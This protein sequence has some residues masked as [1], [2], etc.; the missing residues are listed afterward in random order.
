MDKKY[1]DFRHIMAVIDPTTARGSTLRRAFRVAQA[2][3]GSRVTAYLCV[4]SG[5]SASD[6]E[7][8]IETEKERHKLWVEH[9]IGWMDTGGIPCEIV[10]DY[11][12][13]WGT[14]IVEATRRLSPDLLVKAC[15]RPGGGGLLGRE[16]TNQKRL[17]YADQQLIRETTCPVLFAKGP[18]HEGKRVALAAIAAEKENEV[19][20][21]L[22]DRI[23][24]VGKEFV[25]HAPG[26][27]LHVV[28]AAESWDSFKHPT[29]LLERSGLPQDKV[30][31]RGGKVPEVVAEVAE[32]IGANLIIIGTTGRDGVAAWALGNVA[33]RILD[34][35]DI[36][37]LVVTPVDGN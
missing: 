35:I 18:A 7:T 20:I 22:D 13:D 2:I 6:E 36:D 37:T 34:D 24:A 29:E 5:Y 23:L 28:N 3:D 26:R 33:E 1:A 12:E 27:E 11:G 8:L 4:N 16:S 30:H 17:R 15:H 25:N 19:Y 21:N 10:I 9:H 32:T 14:A 31:S